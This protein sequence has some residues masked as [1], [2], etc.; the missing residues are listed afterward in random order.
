MMPAAA[1]A[2]CIWYF[3]IRPPPKKPVAELVTKTQLST[4]PQVQPSAAPMGSNIANVTLIPPLATQNLPTSTPPLVRQGGL[5]VDTAPAG[6]TIMIDGSATKTSPATISNL[7]VGRHQMQ[8]TLEGY[9]TEEMP[10]EI[11]DGQVTSL[12]LITLHAREQSP[13]AAEAKSKEEPPTRPSPA[14]NRAKKKPVIAAKPERS[15]PAAAQEAAATPAPPPAKI[16]S[17]PA[18]TPEQKR[19]RPEFEGSAPGG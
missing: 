1:A 14:K 11:N 8:I 17:K 12:G 2:A 15:A 7:P 4:P 9:N 10:V 3:A 19:R 18:A 5:F 16:T 6:A 13:I